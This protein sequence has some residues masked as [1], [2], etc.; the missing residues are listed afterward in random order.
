MKRFEKLADIDAMA[1]FLNA[2]V[3]DCNFCPCME[4]GICEGFCP[5]CVAKFRAYLYGECD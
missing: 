1:N 2:I 3:Q 5:D 4:V